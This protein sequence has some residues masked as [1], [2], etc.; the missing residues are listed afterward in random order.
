MVGLTPL[1]SI[2]TLISLIAVAAGVIAFVRDKG[3]NPGNTLGKVYI[4]GTA[5]TALTGLGVFAHGG[6]GKPH[7]LSIITLLTLAVAWA[8]DRGSFGAKARYV[9][10]LCY[11]ATFLFHMIPAITET[12]TRLPLGA[13]LLNSPEAPELQAA[14]G[15]LLLLYIIGATL[16]VRRLRAR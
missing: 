5:L 9:S 1:G 4:Y 6:F 11:S 15:L 3:I 16:Q 14:T 12:S 7:A 10:T 8:A 2:H 13:P